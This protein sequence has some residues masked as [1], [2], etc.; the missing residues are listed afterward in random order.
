MRADSLILKG[1]SPFDLPL[2]LRAANS[3]AQSPVLSDR[4][5]RI[6][7]RI[8]HRP[9]IIMVEETDN[10]PP[11]FNVKAYPRLTQDV[12]RIASYVL[13]LDLDLRPFYKI[14]REVGSFEP[15]VDRLFGLRPF[16][17][18]SLFE[19]V[20]TA[21]TEQQISLTLAH[22]MRERIAVSFGDVLENEFILPDEFALAA[23]HI[24]DLRKC[25]LSQRK[26]E[27]IHDISMMLAEGRF[28]FEE[29]KQMSDDDVYRMLTQVRGIGP[30][31]ADYIMVRGLGRTNRVPA[32]DTG[33]RD[34]VGKYLGDGGRAEPS[35]V[36]E[37][38]E[39]FVPYRGLAAY[40][41]LV[42][43]RMSWV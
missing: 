41:L 18:T 27:Y 32:E 43:K 5:M 34:V 20:I 31:S 13:N 29:L 8:D 36:Y 23:A 28:E 10:H 24:N 21:I 9:F 30:W 17:S 16:R 11:T 38:L 22:R 7:T 12:K 39:P 40:Y 3:F 1:R 19:M 15:V 25:G 14:A 42:D 35:K 26:A 4:V 33:I 2:S 6:S 37:L